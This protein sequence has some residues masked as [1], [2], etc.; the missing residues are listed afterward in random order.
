MQAKLADSSPN[1]ST[2][3]LGAGDTNLEPELNLN[4]YNTPQAKE[5]TNKNLKNASSHVKNKHSQFWTLLCKHHVTFL[6]EI[7]AGMKN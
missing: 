7:C 5:N 6:Y 2:Q 4:N 3:G 1:A